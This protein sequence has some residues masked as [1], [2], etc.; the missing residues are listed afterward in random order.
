MSNMK[1]NVNCCN[2]MKV[3]VNCY[4]PKSLN[5]EMNVFFSRNGKLFT[6]TSIGHRLL[7]WR[8]QVEEE[9]QEGQEDV[10]MARQKGLGVLHGVSPTSFVIL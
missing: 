5:D 6:A 9:G 2:P 10:H 3:K 7:S 4:N 8:D 1:V